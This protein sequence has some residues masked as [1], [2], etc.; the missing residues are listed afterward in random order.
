MSELITEIA[1]EQTN[2]ID[3]TSKKQYL[4]NKITKQNFSYEGYNYCL[5]NY[6]DLMLSDEQCKTYFVSVLAKVINKFLG[7][8]KSVLV[9]GLG[10]RHISADGLGSETLKHIIATRGVVNTKTK[11]SAISTSVLG[12]T[13]IESADII[14]G[15]LKI[16]KPEAIVLIDTL[17]ATDYNT[18]GVNFQFSTKALSPGYGVGNKR[19]KL[20]ELQKEVKVLSIGVPLVV[21]AKSFISYAINSAMHSIKKNES[22]GIINQLLKNDFNNL[23]LTPKDINMVVNTC[24]NIIG[25][26][27]NLAFN[28]YTVRDQRS[29]LQKF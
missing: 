11:V 29:I 10:N 23:V 5:V 2:K 18:L 14:S 7:D 17:C 16:V 1:K 15:V 3:Y 12:L 28:G 9:V 20:D 22:L 8:V 4:K 19:K 6:N 27:I 25:N 24:G 13:G 26:A 21:Y